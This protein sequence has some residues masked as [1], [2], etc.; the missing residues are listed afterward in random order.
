MLKKARLT[1]ATRPTA[2][3]MEGCKKVTAEEG[4]MASTRRTW[5]QLGREEE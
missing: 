2:A 1:L 5:P 3:P 4:S